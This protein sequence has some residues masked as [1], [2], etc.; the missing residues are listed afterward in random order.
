VIDDVGWLDRKMAEL[1][2]P[3]AAPALALGFAIAL[4]GSAMAATYP[5]APPEIFTPAAALRYARTHGI[6]GRVLNDYNFGGYL[7]FAGVPTFIDGRADMYGDAFV[8]RWH[9]AIHATNDDLAALL[10]EYDIAW[11]LLPPEDEA[12]RMLDLMPG[13]RRAYADDIAIIHVRDGVTPMR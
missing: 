11:T 12:V 6:T 13:W 3:A 9:Q 4:A 5:I 1:A 10:A 2:R 8:R 7:I